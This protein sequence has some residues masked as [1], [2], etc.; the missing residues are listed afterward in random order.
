MDNLTELEDLARAASE[1]AELAA[2][3]TDLD[4]KASLIDLAWS[5]RHLAQNFKMWVN[6]AAAERAILDG[7]RSTLLDVSGDS[8]APLWE[9]PS[10][11]SE[12]L[13]TQKRA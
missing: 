10:A 8:L 9:G 4:R 3:T 7:A 6:M 2:T 5:Y 13:L 11:I 12:S 1:C